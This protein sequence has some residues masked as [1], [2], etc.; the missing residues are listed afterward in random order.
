MKKRFSPLLALTILAATFPFHAQAQSQLSIYGWVDT[1]FIKETGND[2]RMGENDSNAIG[3]KGAEDLGGGN[4]VT[5]DLQTRF[6]LNN[7]ERESSQNLLWEGASNMGLAGHW[8]TFRLGRMNDVLTESYRVLDPLNQDGPGSMLRSSQRVVRIGNTARYDSPVW[9]GLY[10]RTSYSLGED[11]KNLEPGS[12]ATAGADNPGYAASLRYDRGPLFLLGSWS[13]GAD[14]N[15]SDIWNLGAAYTFGPV[16]LSLGYERT[17]DKGWINGGFSKKALA[18]ELGGTEGITSRQ[19]SWLA[20]L[21]WT[22]GA[23]VVNAMFSYVTLKD[24]EVAGTAVKL[25]EEKARKYGLGYTYN[26]SKRTQIYSI[27]SYTDFDSKTIASFYR[28]VPP[29][30]DS[31]TSFQLGMFHKF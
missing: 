11:R 8:G 26:L 2:W 31:I 28:G 20:G 5:F 1:G 6:M 25:D 9:H 7:G 30:G 16:R 4:K 3:F 13:R 18:A 29:G 27:V 21:R 23:G 19:D 22:A 15:D 12:A 10:L 24:A 14:S 17:R